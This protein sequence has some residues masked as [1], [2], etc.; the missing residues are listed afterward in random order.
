MNEQFRIWTGIATQGARHME[1]FIIN[2]Y[3]EVNLILLYI[4]PGNL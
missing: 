3:E 4:V 2:E 1:D